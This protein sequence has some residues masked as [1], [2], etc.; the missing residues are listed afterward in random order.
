[1]AGGSN[2]YNEGDKS[3]VCAGE[4]ATEC[5]ALLL[6]ALLVFR[7]VGRNS[8][9]LGLLELFFCFVRFINVQRSG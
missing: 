9:E 7:E 6:L 3:G 4:D 5:M 2:A 1:V 8:G